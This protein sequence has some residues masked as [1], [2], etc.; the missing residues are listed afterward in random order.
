MRHC[1]LPWAVAVIIAFSSSYEKRDQSKYYFKHSELS[2]GELHKAFVSL[3]IQ[4]LSEFW[5]KVERPAACW[6][7]QQL[8]PRVAF[9]PFA[10]HRLQ[11]YC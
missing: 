4:Q 10:K 5:E 3:A 1:E 7:D 11:I 8:F 6:M 2:I 9:E